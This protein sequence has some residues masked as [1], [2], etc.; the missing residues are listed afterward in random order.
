M[1]TTSI[2]CPHCGNTKAVP[3]AKLP[4][5]ITNVSCRVCQGK[6][7]LEPAPQNNRS[8]TAEHKNSGVIPKNTQQKSKINSLWFICLIVFSIPFLKRSISLGILALEPNIYGATSKAIFFG[9]IGLIPF[10][11]GIRGL[12]KKKR[13][14][15]QRINADGK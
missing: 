7:D 4:R 15:N 12:I 6:F 11:L 1:T 14:S 3:I 8:T 9:I 2:T 13:L 10:F 5:K